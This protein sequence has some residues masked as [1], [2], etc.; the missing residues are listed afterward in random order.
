MLAVWSS[1]GG[2]S[3]VSGDRLLM[4][5]GVF[6]GVAMFLLAGIVA[7][8]LSKGMVE[9]S[10]LLKG[11]GFCSI[12]WAAIEFAAILIV[13]RCIWRALL[14]GVVGLVPFSGALIW[15]W[16]DAKRAVLWWWKVTIRLD[17]L[18]DVVDEFGQGRKKVHVTLPSCVV[19]A[20]GGRQS[21][22][23]GVMRRIASSNGKQEDLQKWKHKW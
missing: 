15:S 22:R 20:N 8:L 9:R 5:G 10:T 21:S 1:V 7:L 18:E 23:Q 16:T 6:G 17:S 14:S 12:G 2:V 3:L 4:V 13:C 19:A 11:S